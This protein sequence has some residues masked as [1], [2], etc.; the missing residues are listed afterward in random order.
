MTAWSERVRATPT[1]K[2]VRQLVDTHAELLD[3]PC[4]QVDAYIDH[5]MDV[6]ADLPRLLEQTEGTP[7]PITIRMALVLT[8]DDDVITR[9]KEETARLQ[10]A[11]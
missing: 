10:H 6:V 8:V 7:E 1:S 3:L 2:D 5:W 4:E 9:F 11:A